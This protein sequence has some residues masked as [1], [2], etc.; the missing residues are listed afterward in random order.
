MFERIHSFGRQPYITGLSSG[1]TLHRSVPHFSIHIALS[2]AH[3]NVDNAA[4]IGWAAMHRFLAGD[5]DDLSIDL[6]VKWDIEEL[7]ALPA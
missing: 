1:Q 2:S 3:A 6:R 7:D 4:M 5:Y